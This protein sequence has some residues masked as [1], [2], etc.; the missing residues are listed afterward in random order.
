MPVRTHAKALTTVPDE[1]THDA[2]RI[3]FMEAALRPLGPVDRELLTRFYVDEQPL[4]QICLETG[5]TDTQ[6]RLRK[7]G[8][9]AKLAGSSRKTV[10]RKQPEIPTTDVHVDV[11]RLVPI[12]AHAVAVLSDEQRASHWLASPLPLLGNRSPVQIITRGG[13]IDVIDQI[14]TRIEHNIPS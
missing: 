5:L 12:V 4:K 9:M 13:D 1:L 3:S 8:A 6:F 2:K 10:S 7:S 14:L 11:E